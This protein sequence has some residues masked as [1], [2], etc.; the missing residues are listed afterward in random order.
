M[1]TVARNKL[2]AFLILCYF[3]IGFW[4]L[5]NLEPSLLTVFIRDLVHK[6][7]LGQNIPA[8][9]FYSLDALFVIVFGGMLSYIWLYLE[10]IKRNPSLPMKFSMSLLIMSSGF[11]LLVVAIMVTGPHRLISPYFIIGTYFL[12]A[13][14]ELMISPI[15]T[16]MVGRLSPEGM[17]GRLMGV[18]QLFTGVAGA[19]AGL[20]AQWAVIPEHVQASSGHAIYQSAF[21][22]IGAMT[23][24]IGLLA[25][26]VRP[27]ILKLIRSK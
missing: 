12:L 6:S 27:H 2:L 13:T 20:L 22:K 1:S 26:I 21:S 3:S 11:F 19:M 17:E 5:Y 18:W 10:R 24:I 9:S 16:S 4:A 14:A 25:L 8:E 23:L 7:I 15:G